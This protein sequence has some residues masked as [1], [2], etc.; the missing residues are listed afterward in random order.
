M[1]V[2]PVQ[3]QHTAVLSV[4]VRLDPLPRVAGCAQRHPVDGGEPGDES[5]AIT[6]DQGGGPDL[7]PA[8]PHRPFL[9]VPGSG[10]VQA[11]LAPPDPRLTSPSPS[12]RQGFRKEVR[13]PTLRAAQRVELQTAIRAR[14]RLRSPPTLRN[15]RITLP[16]VSWPAHHSEFFPFSMDYEKCGARDFSTSRGQ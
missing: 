10:L 11:R 16:Q 6:E 12:R 14:L 5:A 15:A 9:R 3:R 8:G 4:H 7:D 1:L 2:E 13:P